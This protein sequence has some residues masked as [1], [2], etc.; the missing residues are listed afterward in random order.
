MPVVAPWITVHG[1]GEGGPNV[2]VLLSTIMGSPQ[3]APGGLRHGDAD[4]AAAVDGHEVDCFRRCPLG[5]YCQV[6]FVLAPLVIDDDDE[7]PHL[8]S[9][10]ASST[11]ASVIRL[12]PAGQRV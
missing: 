7:L 9:S 3:T 10:M 6:A 2:A 1:D 4:E 8:M 5:R 12:P 11:V